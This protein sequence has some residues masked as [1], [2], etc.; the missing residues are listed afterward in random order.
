MTKYLVALSLGA[1]LGLGSIPLAVYLFSDMQDEA[2]SDVRNESALYNVLNH[3]G[4]T[5]NQ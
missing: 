1:V 2:C 3:C 5:L 4:Q